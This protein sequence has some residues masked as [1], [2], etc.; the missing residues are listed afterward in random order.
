MD[1]PSAKTF[2]GGGFSDQTL[3]QGGAGDLSITGANTFAD[4]TN[5]VQPCTITFPAGQT[6]SV[7]DFSVSGT[8]GNLVT[9]NSSTPGTQW[10]I[11][12]V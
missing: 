4:I 2:A 11:A 10:T 3:N 6:T 7:Q 12:K 9:V 8:A 1:S 5:T